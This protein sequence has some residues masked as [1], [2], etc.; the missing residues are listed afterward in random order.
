MAPVIVDFWEKAEF[1]FE[2][3]P[4]L[5]GLGLGGGVI[6]GHGCAGQS[7][8]G[9]AMAVIEMA[10]VDASMST[11]LMVHNSLAML[12]LDLLGSE[13]QKEQLLPSMAKLEV[14]RM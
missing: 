14:S 4:A 9:A 2:L 12:T 1:P 5:A 10:R 3:V 8:M 13:E 7:I 6:K 11:F